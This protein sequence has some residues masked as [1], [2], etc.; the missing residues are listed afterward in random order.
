MLDIEVSA[1]LTLS[2]FDLLGHVLNSND[3]NLTGLKTAKFC[4]T[5]LLK[6]ESERLRGTLLSA[7]SP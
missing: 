6:V 4:Q 2:I 1:V 3:S 7:L 5:A